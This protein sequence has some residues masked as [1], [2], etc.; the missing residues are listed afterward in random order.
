[1]PDLIAQGEPPR[2]RW[3]R[4]LPVGR[5]L[6]LGRQSGAWSVPWDDRVSRKHA[7]ICWQNGR[8]EVI[9]S[10]SARNPIFVLGREIDQFLLE[11]G[12]HFVIG[13]T[14]FTLTDEQANVSIDVPYPVTE[15]A[16][17]PQY[18]QGVRFRNADQRI[19]VLSRLPEIISGAGSDNEL[20]VRLVNVLLTGI[21]RASAAAIVAVRPGAAGDPVIDVLHWDRRLLTGED[22]QS[23][24]RLILQAIEQ[25]KSVVHVWGGS[26]ERAAG[27]FTLGEDVDWAFCTPVQGDA[28]RGWAIYV[29]GQSAGDDVSSARSTDP[30][31]MRDDLKFTELAASTLSSLREVRLLERS[32]ASLSNFFSPVVLEAL[33]TEDPDRVLAPRE[34]EVCV[35][36]C[37]LRGFSRESEK[38]ADDLL[39][40]LNRVSRALGVM[41]RHIRDQG[42]VVG[43][44][45]GD[46]AMGFWGWPLAQND[47]VER[48]CLAALGIRTEFEAT[49]RREE[50][51]LTDFQIG[52]GIATGRAVAGKIGTVDQVKVTVFGPV[53]NL[54]SRL[55][56][57]T[58]VLRA[59]IL[60][61][62][63]TAEVA[64]ARLSS[65]VGRVR[66]VAV[67][68]PYGMNTPAD[69][70]ELLPPLSEHPDLTDENLAAYE[71][72]LD[73]LLDRDWVKAFQLLHRV[74]ADDQVKDFLTVY[75]A[76]HNRTPPPGW[77]GVIPLQ[78]K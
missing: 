31:D 24:E 25:R 73:A 44:F 45:H 40:L 41:T 10:E 30:T 66:R 68:K 54:A 27:G 8:L 46:A 47:A 42:G 33:E 69:V 62:R 75:I 74:P 48:A 23:S 9:K 35:L 58:K 77:D 52:V 72:A 78:T 26:P 18:L 43:D 16:Y 67:V 12:Q 53:V 51:P 34:T 3:R 15:Q 20:F 55:E 6:T 14:T 21:P 29:T 7:E 11:P 38:S 5:K 39:G 13:G 71:E 50:H 1:M 60:I 76:Q 57:M 64:R 28:C 63:R 37:D 19:D 22:F 32:H 61:D 36:F 17:S 65:E 2:H 59:P 49:A 4:T 56:G 70:S